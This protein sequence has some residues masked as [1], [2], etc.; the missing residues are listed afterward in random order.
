MV[1]SEIS[2]TPPEK[3]AICSPFKKFA[4]L[5]CLA[6]RLHGSELSH[7]CFHRISQRLSFLLS[8]RAL[9]LEGGAQAGQDFA[10]QAAVVRLGFGF[11]LG[12]EVRR[13]TDWRRREL[14]AV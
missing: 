8:G 7:F 6:Q 4:L 1:R 3:H 12:L 9:G 5:H 11:Q 2:E 13:D 14:V 10:V